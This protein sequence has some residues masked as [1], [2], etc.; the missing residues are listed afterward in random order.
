MPIRFSTYYVRKGR[1]GG[2]ESALGGIYQANM[3][4]GIFQETKVT[5]RIST[6]GSAGYSV[7]LTDAPIRHRSGVVVFH[8]T[9][10]HF[11]VEAVQKFGPN[12]VGF[13]LA[14]GERRWYIVGCYLAPDDT[15]TIES[16]VAALK[17]LPRGAELLVVGDFNAKLAEPEGDR[18]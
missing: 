2:L 17:E 7:V 10:P 11:T 8:R 9:V 14:T 3:D 1:N 4:L 15:W 13:Q 5:D 16:V 12:V 6:C 18:R